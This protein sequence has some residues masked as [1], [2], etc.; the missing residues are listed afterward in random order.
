MLFCTCFRNIM[1]RYNLGVKLF[2][3]ATSGIYKRFQN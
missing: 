2:A 1:A 3:A